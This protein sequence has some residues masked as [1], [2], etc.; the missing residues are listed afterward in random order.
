M[1]EKTKASLN[2]LLREMW[3]VYEDAPLP[4]DKATGKLFLQEAIANANTSHN[5]LQQLEATLAK[6]VDAPDVHTFIDAC[7]ENFRRPPDGEMVGCLRPPTENLHTFADHSREQ[8]TTVEAQLKAL[9]DFSVLEAVALA[10]KRAKAA[11]PEAFGGVRDWTIYERRLA[12][13]AQR[14]GELFDLIAT[15][16]T[17]QD[18]KIW[19]DN[20]STRV[21]VGLTDGAIDVAPP[22]TLGKR[23][24]AWLETRPGTTKRL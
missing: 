3:Q 9:G 20:G 6:N 7:F 18:V 5:K 8:L 12:E 11:H 2:D 15:A 16:W 14:L 10:A 13:A 1:E 23:L 21:T 22:D 24:L 4:N 19:R 17:A